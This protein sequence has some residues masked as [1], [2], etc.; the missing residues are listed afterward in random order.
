M[1]AM[2]HRRA[3]ARS[4]PLRHGDGKCELSGEARLVEREL[5]TRRWHRE[6][7]EELYDAGPA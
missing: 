2:M 1:A 6:V 3:A 4:C 7:F 5:E